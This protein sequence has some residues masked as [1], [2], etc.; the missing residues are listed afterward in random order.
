MLRTFFCLYLPGETLIYPKCS[1]LWQGDDFP[2]ILE[3]LLQSGQPRPAFFSSTCCWSFTL[4]HL[5]TPSDTWD[6]C[7]QLEKSLNL[8]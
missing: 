3:Q 1:K 2:V 4:R 8:W 7:P 6:M 5:F